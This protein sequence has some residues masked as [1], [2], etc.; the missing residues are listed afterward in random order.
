MKLSI[1]FAVALLFLASLCRVHADDSS[2][3]RIAELTK[4]L[5]GGNDEQR[6]EAARELRDMGADAKSAVE[7]LGKATRDN[8]DQVYS[9]AVDALANLGPEAAEAINFL[10]ARL[11]DSDQ[12][13]RYRAS[14]ALGIIRDTAV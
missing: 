1:R 12:Q 5:S 10:I 4:Q 8:D 3:E 13:K 6:R 14:F 11:E 2:G 9:L 7:A